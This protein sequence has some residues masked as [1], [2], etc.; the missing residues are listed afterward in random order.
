M[1]TTNHQSLQNQMSSFPI[2]LEASSSVNVLSDLV[3]MQNV[4]RKNANV[5]VKV[6]QLTRSFLMSS[7]I[8]L[9]LLLF[10]FYSGP[11]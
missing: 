5:I 11:I 8:L 10:H 7:K 6:L 2:K 1:C 4:S 9:K 3:G